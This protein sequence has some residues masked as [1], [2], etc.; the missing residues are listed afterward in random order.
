[1]LERPARTQSP[2]AEDAF[3]R[4]SPEWAA[5]ARCSLPIGAVFARC[6]PIG[7]LRRSGRKIPDRGAWVPVRDPNPPAGNISPTAGRPMGTLLAGLLAGTVFF[8][9]GGWP[10]QEV[11]GRGNMPFPTDFWADLAHLYGASC[12]FL[13][14]GPATFQTLHKTYLR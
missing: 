5:F 3:A 6:S 9:P 7:A 11:S 10:I 8:W 12:R 13:R 14:H 1:M 2:L 4:G